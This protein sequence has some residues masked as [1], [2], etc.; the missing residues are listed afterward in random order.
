MSMFT[1]GYMNESEDELMEKGN[2]GG[3]FKAQRPLA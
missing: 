1:A 3:E 2:V